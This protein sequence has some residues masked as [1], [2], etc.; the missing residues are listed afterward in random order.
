VASSNGF[1]P[2]PYPFDQLKVLTEVANR[3]EGGIVDLS[4]GVPYDKPPVFA[5]N[6]LADAEAARLYP[7]ANGTVLFRS[8]AAQWLNSLVGTNLS[9]DSVRA[10]IGSKEFVAN[11]PHHLKLRTP[12]KSK[13]LYPSISYPTYAMGATL[14]GCEPVA[15]PVDDSF[16]LDL[17]KIAQTDIDQALCLWVN[18]PA[19]PTGAIEDLES[20]VAWGRENNVLIVSD[21]CYIEFVWNRKPDSALVYGTEGVLAVHSLSKRSNFAGLRSGFYAGDQE[22]VNY[23]GEV[24]KHAGFMQPGPVLASAASVFKDSEH[25]IEQRG[26]YLKRMNLLIDIFKSMGV[27]SGLPEGAFYLWIKSPEGDGW[28]FANYLAEERGM[29]VSPGDF[30]GDNSENY[31][32]VAAVQPDEVLALAAERG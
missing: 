15:V 12:D 2:P 20:I 25:V 29:L 1:N 19:N 5:I 31:V 9:S 24:R 26:I 8:A 30:Y 28:D 14:A 3:H 17:S 18:S 23:L 13:V 16:K 27:E 7:P 4:I 10:T 21:E 11:L 6:L 22:L 32:R